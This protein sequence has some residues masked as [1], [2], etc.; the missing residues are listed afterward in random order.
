M[1]KIVPLPEVPI[2]FALYRYGHIYVQQERLLSVIGPLGAH[3]LH[4]LPFAP[5]TWASY[6]G[7]V[8]LYNN[9]DG[10]VQLAGNELSYTFTEPGRYSAPY[11]VPSFNGEPLIS[12]LEGLHY[13]DVNGLM[14]DGLFLPA[15]RSHLE[16]PLASALLE[17][18]HWLAFSH[19]AARFSLYNGM[20]GTLPYGNP[21][22]LL[23]PYAYPQQGVLAGG[24]EHGYAF[25]PDMGMSWRLRRLEGWG[26]LTER[27]VLQA[28]PGD[29]LTL[30]KGWW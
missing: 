18:D 4:E 20:T 16:V 14:V 12:G 8:V 27:S 17:H 21:P 23:V 19:D 6:G 11:A 30:L 25:S 2:T 3:T 7:S 13:D 10:I 1:K 5:S 9:R 28:V 22:E 26:L 24:F 15:H 29:G